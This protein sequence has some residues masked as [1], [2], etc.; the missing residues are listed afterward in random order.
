L[1]SENNELNLNSDIKVTSVS[2]NEWQ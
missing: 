2:D 1:S